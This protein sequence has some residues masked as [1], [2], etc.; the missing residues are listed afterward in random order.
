MNKL[1]IPALNT[2]EYV[3]ISDI[4]RVEAANSYSR[5]YLNNGRNIVVSKVLRWFEERLRQQASPRFVRTHRTHLVNPDYIT[6]ITQN[7][8]TLSNNESVS[9]AKRRKRGVKSALSTMNG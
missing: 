5:I 7:E 4:V 9:V 2:A 8:V 1:L 6:A 3:T